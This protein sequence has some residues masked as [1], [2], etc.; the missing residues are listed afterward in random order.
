MNKFFLGLV[1]LFGIFVGDVL[2]APITA[3]EL[4]SDQQPFEL[5]DRNLTRTLSDSNGF[6]SVITDDPTIIASNNI[7]NDFGVYNS[8]TVTYR[9]NMTWLNPAPSSYLNATLT[10]LGYGVDGSNDTVTAETIVL[11]NLVGDGSLLEGFTTT[12]FNGFTP[13]QLTGL[14][15]DGYLN[16]SINKTGGR[17]LPDF[18]SIYSSKLEVTYEPVPEPATMLLLGSTVIGLAARRRKIA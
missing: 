4:I 8:S 12:I 3:Y 16:I 14:F 6:F 15:A 2:A 1:V 5:F 18:M 10:I 17:V 7:D 11:G 13:L 9:H